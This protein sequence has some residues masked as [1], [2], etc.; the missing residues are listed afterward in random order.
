MNNIQKRIHFR[1]GCITLWL[2]QKN[3]SILSMQAKPS[4]KPSVPTAQTGALRNERPTQAECEG[5]HRP[6]RLQALPPAEHHLEMGSTR[7]K[8]QPNLEDV[9]L[10]K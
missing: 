4:L 3:P 6:N 10:L 9:G 1:R 7:Q 2:K 8:N 5:V